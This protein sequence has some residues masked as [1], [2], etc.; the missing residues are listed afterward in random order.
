MTQ[1]IHPTTR[2]GGAEDRGDSYSSNASA[3]QFTVGDHLNIPGTI[4]TN[5]LQEA[6][7]ARQKVNALRTE[8]YGLLVSTEAQYEVRL[9]K[10]FVQYRQ[11]QGIANAKQAELDYAITWHYQ[12]YLPV[13]WDYSRVTDQVREGLDRDKFQ[14][15]IREAATREPLTVMRDDIVANTG[16]GAT[17]E[18]P[19]HLLCGF[20]G[21]SPN[22]RSGVVI[23]GGAL[24]TPS[25]PVGIATRCQD[26]NTSQEYDT[27]ITGGA[28]APLKR[29]AVA[30]ETEESGI[31]AMD[32]HNVVATGE[33]LS[34]AMEG[35]TVTSMV[36]VKPLEHG[37]VRVAQRRG[38]LR[39][40]TL[41]VYTFSAGQ[42]IMAHLSVAELKADDPMQLFELYPS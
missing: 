30:I 38:P 12:C 23:N 40:D 16:F 20:C 17:F 35:H 6:W 29:A 11:A 37:I 32:A 1:T 14:L 24:V 26:G 10:L 25:G 7:A 36:I 41:G 27:L 4:T 8:L 15:F 18:A 21:V 34:Q 9:H 42:R 5:Q 19:L 31:I 33:A 22:Q 39:G 3:V 28:L 13:K 2:N